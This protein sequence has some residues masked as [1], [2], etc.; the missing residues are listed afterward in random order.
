MQ[1]SRTKTQKVTRGREKRR[2]ATS[3]KK[4]ANKSKLEIE[5]SLAAGLSL[6]GILDTDAN[7]I[8]FRNQ[9]KTVLRESG[10]QIRTDKNKEYTRNHK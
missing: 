10:E 2:P 9:Y 5:K 3:C 1:T 4:H 7:V 6:K 8:E